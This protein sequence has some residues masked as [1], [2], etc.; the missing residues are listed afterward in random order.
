MKVVCLLRYDKLSAAASQVRPKSSLLA[1]LTHATVYI[2]GICI[3]SARHVYELSFD[4]F[5]IYI[6]HWDSQ[7]FVFRFECHQRLDLQ[8]IYILPAS[9]HIQ[10][11]VAVDVLCDHGRVI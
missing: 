6:F 1:V 9:Q 10:K 7:D 5:F 8:N 3:H 11:I 4:M 2:S